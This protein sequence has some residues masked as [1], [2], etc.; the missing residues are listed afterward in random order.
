MLARIN[1]MPPIKPERWGISATGLR[2]C[3][4]VGHRVRACL[5]SLCGGAIALQILKR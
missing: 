1:A 3:K 4:Q 2:V 5:A